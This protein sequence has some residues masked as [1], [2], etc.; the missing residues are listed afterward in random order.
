MAM[1]RRFGSTR[2]TVRLSMGLFRPFL[3]AGTDEEVLHKSKRVPAR[4]FAYAGDPNNQETWKLPYL[5]YEGAPDKRRLSGAI[6][7]I[8]TN[9]RGGNVNGIPETAVPDVLVRLE[10]A[11]WQAGKMPGQIA[12]P[13]A[14]YAQLHDALI[15]LERLHDIEGN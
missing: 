14:T 15:Q 7:C 10:K 9:C 12:K 8:V 5:T 6:G 1:M 13:A 2:R 11:A 3:S 4:C